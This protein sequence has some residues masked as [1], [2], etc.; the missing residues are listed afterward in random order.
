MMKEKNAKGWGTCNKLRRNV[1][2]KLKA[3][4]AEV[5]AILRKRIN[6]KHL[7]NGVTIIDPNMTYIGIDVR[8]RARYYNISRQCY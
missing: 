7:E 8:D 5:E 6:N 4:L 3:Q 2:G 1:R